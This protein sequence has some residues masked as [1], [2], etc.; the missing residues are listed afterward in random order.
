MSNQVQYYRTEN[1]GGEGEDEVCF[2]Y[3]SHPKQAF[4][5]TPEINRQEMMVPREQYD[6]DR[7]H[8]D[9]SAFYH[10]QQ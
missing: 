9:P 8:Q 6:S 3:E 7:A 2:L 5:Y 4:N 1:S 10:M